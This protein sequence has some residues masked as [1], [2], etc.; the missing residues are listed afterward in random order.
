MVET[1]T[2]KIDN[3]GKEM[4]YQN[5]KLHRKNGPAIID[6]NGNKFWFQNNKLHREDGPAIVHTNGTKEWWIKDKK[7]SKKKFIKVTKLI[8]ILSSLQKNL[9]DIDMD[10]DMDDKEKVIDFI[11]NKNK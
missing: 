1:Y 5:G 8:K 4:W 3:A 7:L 6:E 2:V 10:Y 9:K 11:I